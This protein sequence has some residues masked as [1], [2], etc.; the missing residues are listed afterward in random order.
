MRTS[1]RFA[2]PAALDFAVRDAERELFERAVVARR[3][4]IAELWRNERA[5]TPMP[6]AS[7]R[8]VPRAGF[9]TLGL[10]GSF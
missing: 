9:G 10:T 5:L 8:L 2:R 1:R 7:L 4:R 6:R 3:E